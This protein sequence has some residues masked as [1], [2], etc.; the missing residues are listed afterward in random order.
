MYLQFR[1]PSVTK[2]P[3]KR[4]ITASL[5]F[6]RPG[7]WRE[8]LGIAKTLAPLASLRGLARG[9]DG[10]ALVMASALLTLR[11]YGMGQNFMAAGF[12][13]FAV[14]EGIMVLGANH[15]PGREHAII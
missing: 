11:Y 1:V 4:Q 3:T 5:R 13:V 6:N 15:E 10:V 12:F 7:C 8:S 9:I 14:G 2:V